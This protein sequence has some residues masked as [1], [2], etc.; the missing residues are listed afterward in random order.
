M[1]SLFWIRK[2]KIFFQ[3]VPF[4]KRQVHL[5][6]PYSSSLSNLLVGKDPSV[7]F[8]A[9]SLSESTKSHILGTQVHGHIVKLGLIKDIFLQ[10]N[11]IKMYSR[12]GI[13]SDGLKLFDEMPQKNL[14]SWTL[15]ISATFQ[16]GEFDLGL[17]IFLD[18]VRTGF[19]P[20][21]YALGSVVKVS[22]I[23]GA[24]EFGLFLHCI[25]LKICMEKNPF[26]GC[27][28]LDFY[29]K[30]GDIEAAEKVFDSVD[31]LDVASCNAMVGAYAQC[32]YGFEAMKLISSM[33][34]KE[35]TMDKYSF[36]N[37]LQGCLVTGDL[38][39]GRQIH[40]LIIC[41]DVESCS[42]MNAL[43]DMYIKFGGMDIALKIFRRI[44][45]KDVV[46]WNTLLG[47]FSQY[48]EVV[49]SFFHDLML[50]S[51]N[52]NHVTFSI[53]FRQCGELFDINLGLQFYSVALHLGHLDDATVTSSL[54]DMF[55][56][57]K[58]ME[59]AQ[60][61][62]DSAI[63]KNIINWN[64]LIS[65]YN[66]NCCYNKAL[67][68]FCNLWELGVGANDFT[69][70][71]ILE[72]CGSSGNQQ[73]VRQIHGAILKSGFAHKYACSSLIAAYVK[74]RLLDDSFE[75]FTGSE[76]LG[77]V[78]WGA[79]VSALVHEGYSYEAIRFF[80]ALTEAGEVPDE[81]ILASILNSCAD[82]GVYTQTKSIHSFVIKLGFDTQVYVISAL[83]DAHAKCGDIKN[84]RIVFNQSLE[85]N[86]T[87]MHN[88][89]IMAYGHH[90]LVLEAMEIFKKMKLAKLQPSHATFVSLV[91]A[92]SHAGLVE[93]GRLLHESM[94]LEY[95]IEPNPDNYGCLVDLLSR[96]GFIE[97]AKRII[98]EMPFPPWPAIWRSLLSGCMKHGSR[99]MEEWAAQKLLQLAPENDPAHVLLSKFYFGSGNWENAAMVR[100]GVMKDPGCS[101]IE[102]T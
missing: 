82:I 44:A 10:N 34:R 92:C 39:F 86:D 64:G 1:R 68:T 79:I 57:C 84:S 41:R 29:G 30:L 26:V 80:H 88:T 16:I 93:Q 67:Q 13:L 78:P 14:V 43:M 62:F 65:G 83:I 21:E 66:L 8:S 18:M 45:N 70:S 58:A 31:S 54:I 85:S 98:E 102:T 81:Y 75:F 38:N 17:E 96:S 9:L 11:L 61:V 32:G 19:V 15:T 69:F 76:R 77:I 63:F 49:A 23:L 100:R 90:G 5:F 55:S 95:G 3:T 51:V 33:V 48:P 27:S 97:D 12:C 40:G 4:H 59:M 53:L 52:P 25:A 7:I 74:L 37:A 71:N 73:M 72:A 56:M 28:I 101:W 22:S 89:M 91:S 94:K 50:T 46:S 99:E 24:I 35:V 36:I 47:G 20:N 60:L 42:V 87:I 2:S 6:R